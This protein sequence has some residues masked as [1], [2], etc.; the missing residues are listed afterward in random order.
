MQVWPKQSSEID[1]KR[2]H[3][4]TRHLLRM[5]IKKCV[6]KY[7]KIRMF[8]AKLGEKFIFLFTHFN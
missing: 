4:T 6:S 8:R 5:A 1:V 7:F 2:I 3:R